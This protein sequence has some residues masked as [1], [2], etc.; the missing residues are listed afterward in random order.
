MAKDK[1]REDPQ[2]GHG[3]GPPD[4]KGR[5]TGRP[6]PDHGSAACGPNTKN[7]GGSSKRLT[8]R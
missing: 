4:G 7:S 6:V 3:H 2:P 5:P 8:L 1:D